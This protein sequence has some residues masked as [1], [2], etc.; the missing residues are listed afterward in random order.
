MITYNDGQVARRNGNS[1][2]DLIITDAGLSRCDTLSHDNVRSDHIAITSDIAKDNV[3]QQEASRTFRPHKML[4][5]PS[6]GNK[7]RKILEPG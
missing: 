4:I 1:V 2:I 6:T 3:K 5:G 7:R